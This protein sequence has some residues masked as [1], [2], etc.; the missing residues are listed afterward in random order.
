M[1]K[2][3]TGNADRKRWDN[4]GPMRPKKIS[5]PNEL[6]DRDRDRWERHKQSNRDRETETRRT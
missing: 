3:K 6:S 5:K 2:S 4:Y 1:A